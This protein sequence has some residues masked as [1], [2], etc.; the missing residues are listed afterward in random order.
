MLNAFLSRNIVVDRDLPVPMDDGIV[1]LA[2]RLL[3]PGLAIS[4]RR[5]GRGR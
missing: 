1:L 4:T 2:D 3:D 5:T